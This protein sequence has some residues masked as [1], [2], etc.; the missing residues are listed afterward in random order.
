MKRYKITLLIPYSQ[1]TVVATAQD[2]HNEATR[3]A[4][5]HTADE[6]KA[7]VQSIEFLNDVQT[8]PLDFND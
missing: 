1:E 5:A 7:I 4:N 3:L 2:A 6:A 8:E